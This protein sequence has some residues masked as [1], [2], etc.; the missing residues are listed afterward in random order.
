MEYRPLG[1]TGMQ[2]SVIGLGTMTWGEQNTVEEA[3]AQLDL[4]VD[5]G[6][7]FIDTAEMYP[8]PPKAE[9]QGAT[10]DHLGRWL[11]M[12]GKRDDLVIATKIAGPGNMHWIRD[13]QSRHRAEHLERALE[14]SLARLRT[15]RVDL[16]Q[17]HWPD[18]R[19]NFFGRLEYKHDADADWTPPEETLE[20]LDRLVKSG[21]VRAV[22]LSNETPWGVMRFLA[23]AEAHGWPRVASVQNPYNLL[24][25]SYEIGL[26]EVSVRE[27]CGL[28]AYS[29]L[30]MGVLSGKYRRDAAWPPEA[31]MS[32]FTRF[33]RYVNDRGL[34]A[35]QKYVALAR[36]HGLDPS[37][38]ALAW[39][40]RQP[41]VT[42]NLIGATTL[43]QLRTNLGSA[44]VTLS[45]EVVAG[46]EAIHAQ[47]PNPCP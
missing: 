2:A 38:M 33:E 3:H 1:R 29:P 34:D 45:D 4:A 9:T 37:Q 31:R 28:L 26:A 12:S 13:G 44:D 19:T 23:V 15:D 6:V 24:N 22:G 5:A 21:K 18:R 41:F 16:Y 39:V 25:R 30:A 20:A 8:V 40:N 46:I 10:E 17:L 32:L 42:S 43:E 35:A 7:T 47:D 36:E 14:D 27:D 11:A